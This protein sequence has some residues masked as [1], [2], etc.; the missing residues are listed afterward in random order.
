MVIKNI[1]FS[2]ETRLKML[3][4]VQILAKAVGST[5]GPMGQNVV[6]E[7][8]YGATTVTKD[9][10][11]VA[12]HIDLSDPIQNLGAQILKQA[13]ART[14]HLAGDG[15]TTATVIAAALVKGAHKLISAGVQPIEIKRRFEQLSLETQAAIQLQSKEVNLEKIQEIATISAN[16]DEELGKLIQEAY[17]YVGA[18]GLITVA[19]SRTG[20]TSLELL[21]GVSIDRGYASPYF[22][23]NAAKGE[24]HFDNAL[25]FI[26][27]SKLRHTQHVVPLLEIAIASGRPLLIIAD[28]IDGQALQM[29]VINKMRG[30]V[31]VAAIAAPSYG[32]NRSELL[33]DLAALTSAKIISL[34]EA[35]RVEDTRKEDMGSAEKIVISKNKTMFISPKRDEDR[36][37]A[38]VEEAKTKLTG[39]GDHYLE[40]QIQKRIADLTAKVAVLHVGAP[41]ETEL[42][43]RKDRID[44]A[45]RAT[46]AAVQKGYL[47]GGGTALARIASGMEINSPLI[48]PI[49]IRALQQPLMTIAENAGQPAEVILDKVLNHKDLESGFNAKTLTMGN[50]ISEGVID[51]AL[52]V[53]QAV[54]NAVSAA[55]MIILSSTSLTNQDR[56]PPYNPGNLDDYAG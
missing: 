45:L 50:L 6:I 41:T 52:V 10:V 32:E 5:L 30:A 31:P 53:E 36:I 13:A 39:E 8:P 49:F 51:P 11:T 7:T 43:E 35:S 20:L 46:A 12:K 1:A 27:D 26:T 48:D 29:L 17:E 44:D 3:E 55:N 23:N 15:T 28:E 19:E 54:V 18:Q 37:S 2:E 33:K 40:K 34:S 4:G 21:P 16:N 22:V 56:T 47:I 42:K 25:V 14:A 38:R 9:G 24:V